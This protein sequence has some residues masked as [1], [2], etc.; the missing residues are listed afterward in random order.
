MVI[1]VGRQVGDKLGSFAQ[2]ETAIVSSRAMMPVRHVLDL[3]PRVPNVLN[4]LHLLLET[5][6]AQSGFG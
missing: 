6:G 2:Q 3:T 1:T 4:R 5:V